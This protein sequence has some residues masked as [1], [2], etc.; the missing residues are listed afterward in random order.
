[1]QGKLPDGCCGRKSM[2]LSCSPCLQDLSAFCAYAVVATP[3]PLSQ[4]AHSFLDV[5]EAAIG[6]WD[7]ALLGSVGFQ[8]SLCSSSWRLYKELR[9]AGLYP[10]N[11]DPSTIGQSRHVSMLEVVCEA[12][13]A[14]LLADCEINLSACGMEG[15]LRRGGSCG[16]GM[17][18]MPGPVGSPGG[19]PGP[20]GAP[21][22]PSKALQQDELC[23]SS[24]R[25]TATAAAAAVIAVSAASRVLP[26]S[27]VTYAAPSDVGEQP[28]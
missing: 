11:S 12:E 27:L 16:A 19:S 28:L 5:L 15:E 4:G 25:V 18:E 21:G 7:F 20:R 8:L 22:D 14:Q 13:D 6:A 26:P 23:M 10:P 17:D 9:M 3:R 24:R 2:Y 1:M